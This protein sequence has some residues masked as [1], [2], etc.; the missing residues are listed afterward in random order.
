MRAACCLPAAACL[1]PSAFLLPPACLHACCFLL[2]FLQV[3]PPSA[4]LKAKPTSEWQAA[5][6][7]QSVLIDRST[8]RITTGQRISLNNVESASAEI[9]GDDGTIYYVFEHVSQVKVVKSAA[10]VQVC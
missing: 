3:G 10:C 2:A 5:E 4:Y 9:R 7:A 8:A 6:V 1:L